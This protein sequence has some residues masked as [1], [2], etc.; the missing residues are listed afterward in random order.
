M[1]IASLK[2]TGRQ[3]IIAGGVLSPSILS[4]CPIGAILVSNNNASILCV[5]QVQTVIT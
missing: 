5:S 2:S 1:C 3:S 4:T